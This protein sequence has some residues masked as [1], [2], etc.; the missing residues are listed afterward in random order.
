VKLAAELQAAATKR[1]QVGRL[2][3]NERASVADLGLRL[4][5]TKQIIAAFQAEM[6]PATPASL[7]LGEVV[8]NKSVLISKQTMDVPLPVRDKVSWRN[9]SQVGLRRGAGTSTTN[10]PKPTISNPDC[11]CP[12]PHDIEIRPICYPADHIR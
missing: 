5:E 1:V 7:C 11:A 8:I 2:E 3:R 9:G 12:A 6:V 4:G 10:K